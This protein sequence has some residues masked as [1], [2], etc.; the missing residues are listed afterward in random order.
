V[1]G[2]ILKNNRYFLLE[3]QFP[4]CG[5]IDLKNNR[6]IDRNWFAFCDATN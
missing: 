2:T 6:K 4:F 5:G 1:V 3:N